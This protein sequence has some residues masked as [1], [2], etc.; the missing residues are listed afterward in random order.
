MFY[1]FGLFGVEFFVGVEYGG[2]YGCVVWK[3]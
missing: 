1:E 3:C 2:C